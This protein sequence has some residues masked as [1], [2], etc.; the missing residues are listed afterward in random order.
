[1]ASHLLM[2]QCAIKSAS[3]PAIIITIIDLSQISFRLKIFSLSR[4]LIAHCSGQTN[5]LHKAEMK[6]HIITITRIL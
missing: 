4:C 2:I 1:M 3:I 6:Q 5:F